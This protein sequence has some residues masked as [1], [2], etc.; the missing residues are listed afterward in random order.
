MAL[1]EVRVAYV[2][3]A[4]DA[5]ELDAAMDRC[6][7]LALPREPGPHARMLRCS[8]VTRRP[9]VWLPPRD[10]DVV[11]FVV[12]DEELDPDGDLARGGWRTWGT[13]LERGPGAEPL[14][15]LL[16]GRWER[17]LRAPLGRDAQ[18]RADALALQRRFLGLASG[19]LLWEELAD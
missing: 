14:E 4:G 16:G 3:S 18:A 13:E 15:R 7:W 10:P 19:Y 1:H 17:A 2:I 12:D 6:D 8:Y 5:D 9:D 11:A